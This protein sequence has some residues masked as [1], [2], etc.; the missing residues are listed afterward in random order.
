MNMH[1]LPAFLHRRSTEEGTRMETKQ[2]T[3]WRSKILKKQG[4]KNLNNKE[5]QKLIKPLFWI[6]A[7]YFNYTFISGKYFKSNNFL[8][9]THLSKGLCYNEYATPSTELFD[10]GSGTAHPK[11]LTINLL[12]TTDLL[13]KYL[14]LQCTVACMPS[15][16]LSHLAVL[17]PLRQRKETESKI[18]ASGNK[19]YISLELVK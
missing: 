9:L 6:C 17:R 4:G 19:N 8:Y 16:S 15:H 2:I 10:A 1:F 3:F 14:S 11:S 12:N 7:K 18:A 5:S 13:G